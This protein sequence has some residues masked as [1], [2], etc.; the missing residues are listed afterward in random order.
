[1]ADTKTETDT[2]KIPKPDFTLSLGEKIYLAVS[3]DTSKN[4]V[5]YTLV[6]L[7]MGNST[8]FYL[9]PTREINMFHN[10]DKAQLFLDAV[11]KTIELNKKYE[12]IKKYFFDLNE[13][14]IQQFYTK[15]K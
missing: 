2:P 5:I 3:P 15:T 4:T 9:N 10:A 12:N 8:S 14:E 1:M 6:C 13:E 11:Q 7:R